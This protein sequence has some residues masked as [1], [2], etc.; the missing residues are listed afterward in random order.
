[1]PRAYRGATTTKQGSAFPSVVRAPVYRARHTS[2][3]R[4]VIVRRRAAVQ[5]FARHALRGCVV[6]HYQCVFTKAF[7]R[8]A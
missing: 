1:M 3:Q 8:C 6:A 4:G 7:A 5:D 2:Q